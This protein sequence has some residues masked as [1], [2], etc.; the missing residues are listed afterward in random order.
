MVNAFAAFWNICI[1][2]GSPAQAPADDQVLRI[3]VSIVL[4]IILVQSVSVGGERMWPF[5]GASIL[6]NV[7]LLVAIYISLR[8][9]KL[10]NRLRKTISAYL[11]TLAITDVLWL[12]AFWLAAGNELSD[13]LIMALALWRIAVVGF[14]LKHS[15]DVSLI[16]GLLL[17]LAF[18]IMSVLVVV[19]V[20]P[21]PLAEAA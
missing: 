3:L 9:R 19:M 1:F 13:F 20:V 8:I 2:R 10:T 15:L 4:A 14:I 16:V 18:F 17:A 12:L 11:G 21:F 6:S 5:A 7:L